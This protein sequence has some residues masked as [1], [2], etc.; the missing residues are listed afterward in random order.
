MLDPA[1]KQPHGQSCHLNNNLKEAV[2]RCKAVTLGLDNNDARKFSM[3]T[4]KLGVSAYLW[5]YEHVPS[6]NCI[7]YNINKVLIA[8]QIVQEAGGVVVQ[9]VGNRTGHCDHGPASCLVVDVVSNEKNE[10][11]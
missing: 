2:V 11:K 7:L 10:K 4:P 8:L 9:G 5:C 6:S 3:A 1:P